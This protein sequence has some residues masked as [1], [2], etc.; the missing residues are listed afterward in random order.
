[1]ANFCGR[2]GRPLA[3]GE[4]CNCGAQSL[5]ESNNTYSADSATQTATGQ[6]QGANMYT[7]GQPVQNMNQ[8][9]QQTQQDAMNQ[10]YQQT[11]QG[12]MN[13]QSY[14]YQPNGAYSNMGT[15]NGNAGSTMSGFDFGAE[16]KG[17]LDK[18]LTVLK[19]PVDGTAELM[20]QQDS[21][22]GYIA[23]GVKAIL[24]GLVSLLMALTT[25]KSMNA[26]LAFLFVLISFA[27][28]DFASGWIY[29]FF[30][31]IVFK[32]HVSSKSF[33]ALMG[34]KCVYEVVVFLVGGILLCLSS[35]LGTCVLAFGYSY[36]VILMITM[37]A[38]LVDVAANKK[39][40]FLLLSNL[41]IGIVTGIM[42]A[43][44]LNQFVSAIME[45]ILG[46]LTGGYGSYHS[47]Y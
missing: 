23:I 30:G 31:T 41:V 47:F 39:A 24:C 5:T 15:P 34:T 17:F 19:R 33:F 40:I 4:V 29:Y 2:C 12:T 21:K 37:F 9:Y 25:L 44:C 22:F 35:G 36:T 20:Q 1:M 26:F 13:Q 43:I 46:G 32:S 6:A 11:Q 16:A 8:G 7:G 14:G 27:I 3:D 38:Q 18:A 28:V 10:G 42:F 45:T